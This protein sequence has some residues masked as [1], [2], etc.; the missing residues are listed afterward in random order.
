MCTT[1]STV[2]KRAAMKRLLGS[3]PTVRS[4]PGPSKCSA[5][6]AP[7][8]DALGGGDERVG[9]RSPRGGRI[10]LVQAADVDELLGQSGERRVVVEVGVHEPRPREARA[11]ADR[12][13]RGRVVDDLA[14][15]ADE[16]QLIAAGARGVDVLQQAGGDRPAQPD[17]RTVLIAERDDA[18]AEPRRDEVERVLGGVQQ[19]LALDVQVE[20]RHIGELR[21]VTV[22]AGGQRARDLL[23]ADLGSDRD[24]LARLNVRAE[25]DEQVGEA[26]EGLR[27]EA[28]T[29]HGGSA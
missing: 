12:P 15:L 10:L 22:G 28:G 21:A 4:V 27:V 14:G 6:K 25:S 9:A 5:S 20:V 1:P 17:A 7:R 19:A 24:D 23:L 18:V 3:S 16:R 11:R 2:S 8:G 29:G 26:F 13:V